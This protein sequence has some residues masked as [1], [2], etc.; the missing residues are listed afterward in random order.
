VSQFK[1]LQNNI[2]KIKPQQHF[3]DKEFKINLWT[4]LYLGIAGLQVCAS[5]K[6]HDGDLSVVVAGSVVQR[7][8]GL[9]VASTHIL[10]AHGISLK[11]VVMVAV[12]GLLYWVM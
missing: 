4:S 11:Q 3:L 9:I 10:Q 7:C 2:A 12:G 1:V 8:A 5:F 6:Q